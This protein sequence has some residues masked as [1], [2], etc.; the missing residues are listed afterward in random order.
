MILFD[1]SLLCSGGC[2][3]LRAGLFIQASF[4]EIPSAIRAPLPAAFV[5]LLKPVC[6]HVFFTR[7]VD[8]VG[9]IGCSSARTKIISDEAWT[10]LNFRVVC[11]IGVS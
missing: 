7:E 8:S 9:G 2:E 4:L 3:S 10:V 1:V 11:D 5:F 6:A